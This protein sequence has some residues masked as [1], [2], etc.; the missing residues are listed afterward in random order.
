MFDLAT[1]IRMN[2]VKKD[3]TL[4][5]KAYVRDIRMTRRINANIRPK[6]ALTNRYTKLRV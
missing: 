1:I 2:Y 4:D 3:G 6:N 5:K